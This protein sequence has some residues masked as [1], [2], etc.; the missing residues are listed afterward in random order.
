M[1]IPVIICT[2]ETYFQL[3]TKKDNNKCNE[4]SVSFSHTPVVFCTSPGPPSPSGAPALNHA[5]QRENTLWKKLWAWESSL[6]SASPKL[7]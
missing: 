2:Y 7:L 5:T 6:S 4:S 3:H 1:Y